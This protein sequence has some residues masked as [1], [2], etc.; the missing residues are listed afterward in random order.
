V[1]R[2]EQ[3]HAP[4]SPFALAYG[5]LD[6]WEAECQAGIDAGLLDPRDVPVA[7]MAVRRW[8]ADGAWAA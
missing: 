8:H 4:T 6:A 5:S 3:S 1:Q 7:V 2:L